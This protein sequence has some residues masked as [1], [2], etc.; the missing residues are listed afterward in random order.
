MFVTAVCF[1]IPVK[2][3]L[4]SSPVTPHMT[5]IGHAHDHVTGKEKDYKRLFYNSSGRTAVLNDL[6]LS[7]HLIMHRFKTFLENS[8]FT[9][10][11]KF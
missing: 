4:F 2:V 3:E 11:L 7:F 9:G 1:F 8:S 5:S 6:Y 10:H